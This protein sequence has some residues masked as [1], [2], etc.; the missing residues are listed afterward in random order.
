MSVDISHEHR[1][2]LWLEWDSAMSQLTHD[3]SK[4]V[5]AA[6][7]NHMSGLGRL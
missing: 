1:E 6:A 2:H 5:L 7:K 3:E 4:G